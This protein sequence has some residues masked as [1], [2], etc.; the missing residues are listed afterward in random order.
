MARAARGVFVTGTDTGVGKTV[1][2]CALA[3]GLRA[4]GVDVGAIKPIETGVGPAGPA[5]ALALRAGACADDPLDDVCPL[6]FALPAAPEAAARHAGGRV[7]LRVIDAA[8]ARLQARHDCV[9]A[10]GAGGLLAPIAPR[11]TMADLAARLA[12][13]LVIV[14][15]AALGT[16]N[17]TRLTLEAA[18]HRGLAVLGVVVSHAGGPL[19]EAD[20]RNLDLLR[21]D[22][23]VPWLGEIPPLGP[24]EL[25]APDA[26]DLDRVLAWQAA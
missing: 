14:A 4:R 11:V 13:P 21:A 22:P 9:I 10:E 24:A 26:L 16:V 18:R 17:H 12:L 23:D 25:P 2:A 6:R 15:R 20:A 19:S 5:D 7:D 3:R 1:A 8:L